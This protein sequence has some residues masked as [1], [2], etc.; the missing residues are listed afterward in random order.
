[1]ANKYRIEETP[2]HQWIVYEHK[3]SRLFRKSIKIGGPFA[4]LKEAE[5]F[6]ETRAEPRLE[7]RFY[8]EYGKEDL[9][10]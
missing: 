3:Y 6:L 1:M 4:T 2:L 7:V 10:W 9:S 8:N 5:T